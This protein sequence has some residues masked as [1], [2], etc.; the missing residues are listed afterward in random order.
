MKRFW[1]PEE[2]RFVSLRLSMAA[3]RTID[4]LGLAAVIRDMRARGEKV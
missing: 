4:R 3:M 1:F 2:G